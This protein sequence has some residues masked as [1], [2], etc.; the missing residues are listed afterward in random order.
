MPERS[1]SKKPT[2]AD[3]PKRY[4]MDESL[5]LTRNYIDMSKDPIL[6]NNQIFMMFW[7]WIAGLPRGARDMIFNLEFF[8]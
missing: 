6:D 7:D 5:Y 2:S 4:S 8:F 3:W 1:K